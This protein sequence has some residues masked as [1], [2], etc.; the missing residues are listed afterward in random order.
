MQT[1]T[2]RPLLRNRCYFGEG[3]TRKEECLQA[4]QDFE[5]KIVYKK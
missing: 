4:C 1:P 5:K 3:S 2:N